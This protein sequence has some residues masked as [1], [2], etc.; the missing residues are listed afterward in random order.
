VPSGGNPC[1]ARA[2]SGAAQGHFVHLLVILDKVDS[3]C[4]DGYH[5]AVEENVAGAEAL[6]PRDSEMRLINI[7]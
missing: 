2:S 7:A 3:M 5:L 1:P 6:I 4:Y